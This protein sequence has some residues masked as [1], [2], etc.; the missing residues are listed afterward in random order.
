MKLMKA[1]GLKND[2]CLLNEVC[3]K[4]KYWR[5]EKIMIFTVTD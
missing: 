3:E 4:G 2:Q 1:E 5:K